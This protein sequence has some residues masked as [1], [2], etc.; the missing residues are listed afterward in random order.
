MTKKTPRAIAKDNAWN[1]FSLFIR[2]RDCLRFTGDPEYGKCVTCN[3]PFPLKELQAGHFIDGR[4]NAVLFRED[5]VYSQCR[6]CNQKPPMGL[7]GNHVKYTLFMLEEGY[8][9]EQIEE[10]TNLRHQTIQYK[11]HDFTDIR[12]K[13]RQKL[14]DLLS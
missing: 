9:T 13:Y 7:G 10:L 5:I 2:T 6:H 14:A 1:A 4:G 3:R 11:L 12:E 8:T